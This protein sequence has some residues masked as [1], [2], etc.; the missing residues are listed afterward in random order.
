MRNL[1]TILTFFLSLTVIS[2]IGIGTTTPTSV[3]MLE[4]SSTSDGGTTY[5]GFMPPRVSTIAN[6]NTINP[7]ATD[8]ALIVFVEQT[9]CLQVW[10]GSAWENIH[11]MNTVPV[12]G[13]FQN[14]DLS[15]S[16][17][18]SSDTSF[19]DNGADGFFGITNSTNGGFSN[20]TTLTNNFL[21]ILDLDDEGING[22]SGFATLTFNTINVSSA[23]N[24]V[25]LSFDYEFFEFDN[26]DDVFYTVTIDGIPQTEVQLI[27]GVADLSISGSVTVTASAGTNSISLSIR[28]KQDGASDYGGFDNFA[29]IPN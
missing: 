21:G 5:K 13:V 24:G 22:T 14:F 19:F 2:Q 23:L 8:V 16:W 7:A 27:N 1:F 18:Y 17:G 20:I 10:N 28:I 26:G 3:S 15:T 11:C 6:R 12:T 29:I 4:I 25:T 9:S